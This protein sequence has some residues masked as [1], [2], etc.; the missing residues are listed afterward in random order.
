[1]IRAEKLAEETGGAILLITEGVFGMRGDQGKLKEIVALKKNTIF[2]LFVDDAHRIG[3]LGAKGGGTGQEQHCQ[4]GIDIYFG[5]FAKSF[6]S[7]R[8]FI[9]SDAQVIEFLRYNMRSQMFLQSHYQ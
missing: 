3:T 8:W 4:D 5:T 2:R 7:Y 1:M 6:C 9:S